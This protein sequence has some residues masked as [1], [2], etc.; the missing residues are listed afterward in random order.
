MIEFEYIKDIVVKNKFAIFAFLCAVA[1]II[2]SAFY[3]HL[4]RCEVCSE[5]GKEQV[6]EDKSIDG[7]NLQN[8]TIRIDVK[9]AVKKPG[10][11]EM[12]S[13][14]TINDAI[15]KSGGLTSKGT[16][17]N[18]NLSKKLSDEM[19]VYVFTKDELKKKSTSNEVVCEV[20]KCECETVEIESCPPVVNGNTD[21][22]NKS[23]EAKDQDQ[24]SIEN[25]VSLNKGTVE[26]FQTLDGIGESKAQ[27][28]IE[29][30]N[31]NGPF[32]NIEDIMNVSGIGEKAFEKIKTR[33]TL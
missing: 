28:I 26:D 4:N 10:V 8:N 3:V 17:S 11:Y 18:I 16:T 19:V 21:N 12:E 33:L 31:A 22:A 7:T 15:A 24:S 9:G 20:P 29:Y 14:S 2:G 13:T 6:I 23:D 25:K 5:V 32:K 27:A 30:R 1:S